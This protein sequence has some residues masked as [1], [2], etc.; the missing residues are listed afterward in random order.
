MKKYKIGFIGAGNMG[1][2]MITGIISRGLFEKSQIIASCRSAE[3]IEKIKHTLGIDATDDNSLVAAESEI[4]VLAVKPYQFDDVLPSIRDSIDAETIV[5]SIAAGK[6]ISLIENALISV[7]N[8]GK[9]R[10]VRAMPNTPAM[11][12]EAMTGIAAGSNMSEKDMDIVLP[13]FRSFGQAEVISEEQ[14]DIITGLSGSSPAFVYMMI[15]AM[16]DVAV[17]MGLT[18]AASYTFAS[19]AVLGAAKMVRDTGEHPGALK[20]AVCSPGGTTIAGVAALE[21]DGF[22]ATVADGIRSAI[23]RGKEM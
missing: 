19:Q 2:A 6:S 5:I 14:M 15:E 11:V 10:V 16:S 21:A 23:M 13:I 7:D 8:V 18:R 17:E 4:L 1:S 9:L 20:D 12:G 22:R 3:H